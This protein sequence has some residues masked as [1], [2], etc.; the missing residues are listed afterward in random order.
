MEL[1]PT[2]TVE[3]GGSYSHSELSIKQIVLKQFVKC[4]EEGS[5]E[6][7]EGGVRKRLVD[8]QIEEVAVDNQ[9]EIFINSVKSLWCMLLPTYYKKKSAI[10]EQIEEIDSELKQLNKECLEQHS[11]Y[12][13]ASSMDDGNK[14]IVEE[15]YINFK[16][17]YENK[18]IDIYRRKLIA[19]SF[20][21]DA[22]NY[23]DETGAVYG[24][25]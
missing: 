7:V 5:K 20:L 14:R 6:M 3:D 17:D 1:K 11:N 10:S 8:G 16:L 25:D 23:F 19:M 2:M 15:A 13:S 4:S 18:L 12:M 22:V 24:D 21:L 9:R